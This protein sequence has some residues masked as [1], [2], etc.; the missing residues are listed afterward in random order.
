MGLSA[1][2]DDVFDFARIEL[3]CLA[4]Y[5]PDAVR[6]RSSGR[7]RL[8]DPR[9]DLARAVRELATMTASLI[10]SPIFPTQPRPVPYRNR[11]MSSRLPPSAA[12]KEP[13]PRVLRAAGEIRKCA[14]RPF[15]IPPYRHATSVRPGKRGL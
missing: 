15:V 13:A 2:A 5:I 6:A 1:P 8:N 4:Q 9:N 14:G 7:V 11:Q 12:A 10:T 3:R